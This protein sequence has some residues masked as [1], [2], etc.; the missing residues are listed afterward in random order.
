M[1]NYYN[2]KLIPILGI[3]GGI[4]LFSFLMIYVLKKKTTDAYDEGWFNGYTEAKK[5]FDKELRIQRDK[6]K[7]IVSDIKEKPFKE[8]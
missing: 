3:S 4:S 2:D 8:I 6:Y 7:E 5:D 1:N